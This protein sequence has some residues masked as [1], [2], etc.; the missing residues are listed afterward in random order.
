MTCE[1]GDLN[2]MSDEH[3]FEH[4]VHHGAEMERLYS[5]GQIEEALGHRRRV[6]EIDKIMTNKLPEDMR[7]LRDPART[8]IS[9]D[10]FPTDE[11]V[12][13]ARQDDEIAIVLA[14]FS[15]YQKGDISE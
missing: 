4:L 8:G 5:E 14:A 6:G 2:N 3:L 12:L 11:E 9:W 7:S 1:A 13:A 15:L 10:R